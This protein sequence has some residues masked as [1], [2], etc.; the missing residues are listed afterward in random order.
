MAVGVERL[1][2]E[3]TP[4]AILQEEQAEQEGEG[5]AIEKWGL[6][7]DEEEEEE[8]EWQSKATWCS[9]S[10]GTYWLMKKGS[11]AFLDNQRFFFLKTASVDQDQSV[12]L[13][14]KWLPKS[15]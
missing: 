7:R 13:K 11:E 4:D 3:G 8:L 5:E 15:G 12:D 14:S 6:V 1:A 9:K 2:Y 10:M